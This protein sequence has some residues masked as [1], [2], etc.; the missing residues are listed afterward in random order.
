MTERQIT[1]VFTGQCQNFGFDSVK[2]KPMEGCVEQRFM[3]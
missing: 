2:G 1:Q 3:V